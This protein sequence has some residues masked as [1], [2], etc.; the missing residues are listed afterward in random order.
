[1]HVKKRV[2]VPAIAQER[3]LWSD[4]LVCEEKLALCLNLVYICRFSCN[5]DFGMLVVSPPVCL[6]HFMEG[7]LLCVLN[8]LYK[9]QT[10]YVVPFFFMVLVPV[11]LGVVFEL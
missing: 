2:H 10:Y 7:S 6:D 1:M 5:L 8:D 3:R 4:C 11:V 9:M